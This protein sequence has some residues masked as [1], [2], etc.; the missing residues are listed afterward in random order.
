M[1]IKKLVLMSFLCL[2]YP[3]F[4]GHPSDAVVGPTGV[5]LIAPDSVGLWSVGL[6]ALY[7][8]P[9][10]TEFKYT[11]SSNGSSPV[12]TRRN[13]NVNN[14]YDWGG[15]IDL[16][17]MFPGSS[18]D[19]KLAYTHLN[20][21]DSDYSTEPVGGN[22]VNPFNAQTYDN[23][24]GKSQYDY[25]AIDLV[26][27]QWFTIGERISL[28]PVAG[29]R[30]ASVDIKNNGN[31]TFNTSSAYAIGKS[32]S[33]WDGIGPRVGI[34]GVVHVGSGVS[35]VGTLGSSLILGRVNS[36]LYSTTFNS[37]TVVST[38]F[39]VKNDEGTHV[40][41]ELDARL[42]INY[43]YSFNPATALGVELGYQTVNYFDVRDQD[44]HDPTG[45]NTI[46]NS[47]DFGYHGPYLRVQLSMA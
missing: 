45:L 9:T 22:L 27:G 25:D 36:K 6:E 14:E 38:G 21:Q 42:G 26:F 23:A 24:Y 47:E 35:F 37:A 17:Y 29:L 43:T 34:D 39:N 28:H 5:N 15:T 19:V 33:D 11:Q 12:I 10:N 13:Q 2:S 4:A 7:M 30:Y 16:T 44:R 41:P 46:S 3:A 18:R 8:Q 31:Y 20:M 1:D 32:T 40:I